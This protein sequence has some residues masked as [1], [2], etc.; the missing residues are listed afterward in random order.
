ML[1]VV[2]PIY[3]ARDTLPELLNC[4]LTQTYKMFIVTLS[5]DGDGEDYSD[6]IKEYREKGLHIN[7]INSSINQGPGM[8]RQLGID[9]S[10]KCDYI[11]FCDADDLIT[12]R[13]I[14]VLYKEAKRNMVDILSSDFIAERGKFQSQYMPVNTTP[15]TWFHGKIYRIGYLKENNI[16]FLEGL[17]LNE[18][19]YFNLVA[20]NCTENKRKLPEYT[21]IWRCNENSLT[22]NEGEKAFFLKSWE[23]YILSQVRGIQKI[24]EIKGEISIGVLAATILNLYNHSMKAL[25][26]KTDSS[27]A[28]SYIRELKEVEYIQRIFEKK[29]F[30]EYI[31][32]HLKGCEFTDGN[33]FFFKRRFIDWFN[34]LV[35]ED[36]E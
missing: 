2:I 34:E 29:P 26:F 16:R 9:H 20:V 15:V 21:Y 25:F 23:Q 10:G 11:M 22:R 13:A 32:S 12:P 27:L 7:H 28:N 1:N 31:Y 14:E 24:L 35:A 5:Q 19:S 36:V 18:D 17:R 3:K 33:L 6:I 30:W 8:A 4:L